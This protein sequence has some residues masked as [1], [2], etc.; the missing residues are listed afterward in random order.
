MRNAIQEEKE[1]NVIMPVLDL[2][3]DELLTTT[4]AVRKRLDRRRPVEAE[5]TRECLELAVQAPSPG[6]RQNWHF[7]FV[8]D[9]SQRAA[10]A[11]L[12]R[13]GARATGQEETLERVIAA[14]ADEAAE[15]TRMAD[16]ARYLTEHLH[17]V[18]VHGDRVQARHPRAVGRGEV[19]HVARW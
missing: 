11:A 3:I 9:P 17:E 8:T 2:S 1:R 16:S 6:N 14:A 15:L 19:L 12:Y 18:P 5:V 10:L 7:V 4:R 13:K